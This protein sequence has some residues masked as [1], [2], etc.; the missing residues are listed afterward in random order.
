MD[1]LIPTEE[2]KKE[3]YKLYK[4]ILHSKFSEH[5]KERLLNQAFVAEPWSWR[6]V[7]IT[8]NALVEFKKNN[9][10]YKTGTFYREHFK[11]ARHITMIKI[12]MIS[13]ITIQ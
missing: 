8:T 9:F 12:Y 5:K 3:I 13:V 6:V 2:I 4:F 11:Q 7:G 10:R 1:N